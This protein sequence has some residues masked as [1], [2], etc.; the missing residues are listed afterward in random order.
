MKLLEFLVSLKYYVRIWPRAQ[1]FASMANILGTSR[2]KDYQD[3]LNVNEYDIYLQN[4][5]LYAYEH[6]FSEANS[7][8]EHSEGTTLIPKEKLEDIVHRVLIFEPE[9]NR[10]RFWVNLQSQYQVIGEGPEKD[11][12]GIDADRVVLAFIEGYVEAKRR[13]LKAITKYYYKNNQDP[14]KI[15][16]IE[17]FASAVA[18]VN[19]VEPAVANQVYPK[20]LTLCRSFLYALTSGNN[21]YA[22]T[23]KQMVGG[24]ARF[25]MDC[26]FPFISLGNDERKSK[27]YLN[28]GLAGDL[29]KKKNQQLKKRGAIFQD[30]RRFADPRTND[31]N[32]EHDSSPSALK[33]FEASNQKTFKK[34]LDGKAVHGLKLDSASALFAQQFAVLREL[35]N[36]CKQFSEVV[37]SGD[38]E[39]ETMMKSFRQIAQI[40]ETGCE[41]LKFPINIY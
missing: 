37:E 34:E 30:K 1:I 38:Q 23:F 18:E 25:G 2:G 20:D 11:N 4:Y 39:F 5:V 3:A 19:E 22:V 28:G 8:V 15:L 27:E 16:S 35:N 9:L 21:T 41:F 10:K 31:T 33:N 12:E 6:T 40:L 36:Y 7:L 17:D 24:L 29:F 14:E 32:R 13:N 26:P